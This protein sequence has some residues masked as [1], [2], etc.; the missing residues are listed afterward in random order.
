MFYATE[1]LVNRP[2]DQLLPDESALLAKYRELTERQKGRV[3]QQ[4]DIYVAENKKSSPLIIGD[5][6]ETASHL[7]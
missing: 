2:T 4:V 5:D 7:A 6:E 1:T 3:D